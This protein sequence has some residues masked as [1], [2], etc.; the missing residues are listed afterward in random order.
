MKNLRLIALILLV[1]PLLFAGCEDEDPVTGGGD[2]KL[3]FKLKYGDQTLVMF[4]PYTYPTGQK[5]TFSRFSFFLADL[6]LKNASGSNLI[7]DISYHNLTNSHTGA[8]QAAN[9][10]DFT[11]G[12]VKAGAYTSIRFTLGVPKASNDKTPAEFSNDHI[13][14]N[15]AE[16]WSGWK[17]YVFTKT[18]GLIDFDGDGTT[19]S[20]YA[21]HT[22]AND[23]LR[24]IELPANI[25]V[26]EGKETTVTI[27][28]D[29]KKEFGS[30]PVYDIESNPQIHSL[31]QAPFVKQLADNLTTA[32]TIQ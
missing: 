29:V 3:K 12:G 26:E 11:I 24:T 13:L 8:V 15:Q 25:T 14:S 31:S 16:Y 32:F 22:G 9:G 6:Q 30:N 17:S 5:M 20:G 10:Y 2:L 4:D 7:H 23:A 18:E 27:V 19:E 21:L 28:I 1:L